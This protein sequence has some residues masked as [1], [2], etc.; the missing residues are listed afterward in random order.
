MADLATAVGFVAEHSLGPQ[1]GTP[2][3]YSLHG[4][5]LHHR[6]ELRGFMTLTS[7]QHTGHQFPFPFDP[8]MQ[9]RTE[10]TLTL[11]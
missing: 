5:L 2:S 1:L 8:Q 4:P 11:A 10:T 3:P 9:L 6:L 7:R